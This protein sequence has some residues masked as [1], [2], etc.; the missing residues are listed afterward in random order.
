MLGS[1]REVQQSGQLDKSR[2]DCIP[3]AST[4]KHFSL[5][6]VQ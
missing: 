6:H 4:G 3:S 2:P 1:K 5:K